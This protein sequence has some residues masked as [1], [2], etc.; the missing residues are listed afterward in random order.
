MAVNIEKYLERI[1]FQDEIQINP[2]VLAALHRSHILNIPF[3]N[4]DIHYGR[5]IILDLNQIEQKII[6]NR[7]GGF[8]YELNGLFGALLSQLGFE[9]KLISA[10][11]F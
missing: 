6:A 9:V 4:L 10:R 8:C 2:G 11:V 3:E 1:S 5:K 7:R